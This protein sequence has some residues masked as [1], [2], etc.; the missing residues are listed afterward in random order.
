VVDTVL[1]QP[2]QFRPLIVSAAAL[3]TLRKVKGVEKRTDF[4]AAMN[5]TERLDQ[6]ASQASSPPACSAGKNLSEA[7]VD[8]QPGSVLDFRYFVT[9][10]RADSCQ[11]GAR[12]ARQCVFCHAS[13]VIFKLEPP[14]SAGVYSDQDSKENYKYAMRVWWTSPIPN[15]E[16]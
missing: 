16:A 4:K 5:Q 3:D 14:N 15:K 8:V 12:R 13:H 2:A 7:L 10:H 11:T 9:A 1:G 6:S